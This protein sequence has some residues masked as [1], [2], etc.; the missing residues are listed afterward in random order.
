VTTVLL[1][2]THYLKDN[3]VL[4]L[5]F[6]KASAPD[7][8]AVRG[9]AADDDDFKAGGDKV[10]YIVPVG[11]A[12]GPFTVRAELWYQPISFR[13]ARNVDD[14]P[15]AEAARFRGY[16]ETMSSSSGIV[17]AKTEAKTG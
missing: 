14:R 7:D 9:G 1:A 6:D 4:P 13:W 17:L 10:R 3:R 16:F 8:V 12:S 11:A 15:S 5:G 2:A